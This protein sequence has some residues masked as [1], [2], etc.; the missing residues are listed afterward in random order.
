MRCVLGEPCRALRHA[1]RG[2]GRDLSAGSGVQRNELG[3]SKEALADIAPLHRTFV[4]QVRARP[5]QPVTLTTPWKL[6]AVP[7]GSAS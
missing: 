6:T 7:A 2:H 1:V 5:A 3:L 4:G